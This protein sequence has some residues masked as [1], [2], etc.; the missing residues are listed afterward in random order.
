MIDWLTGEWTAA[1]ERAH[2]LRAWMGG[3]EASVAKVWAS[4]LL[5]HIENDLGRPARAWQILEAELPRA[6]SLNDQQ[7]TVP[8]LAQLARAYQAGG[9]AAETR[10]VM[11]EYLAQVE[12]TP[13]FEINAN[14]TLLFACDWLLADQT[15]DA[16]ESAGQC[17]GRL[18]QASAQQHCPAT[19]A[20]W[21]EAQGSVDL[22]QGR[23][24]QAAEHLQQAAAQWAALGHA[25]DEMRALVR[26]SRARQ[27]SGSAEAAT[28]AR[29][30]AAALRKALAAQVADDELRSA[31]LRATSDRWGEV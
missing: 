8:H 25:Y 6:R 3:H 2:A 7:S 19:T 27:A 23:A 1:L 31:F 20:A 24:A 4:T 28:K 29:E 18:A 12:R 17:L 16:L 9:R 14:A 22:A 11:A 26:L 15:P 21:H 5:G 10:A 30:A 13:P